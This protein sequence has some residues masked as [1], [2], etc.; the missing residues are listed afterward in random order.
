M[1]TLS[2]IKYEVARFRA[3]MET[4]DHSESD[5]HLEGFPLNTCKISSLFL[6]YHLFQCFPDIA[7]SLVY[8]ETLNS[9]RTDTIGH[10]WLENCEY[11]IDITADQFNSLEPNELNENITL[12]QP[13]EKV[14][15]GLINTQP[16]SAIFKRGTPEVL[17]PKF[18]S[19]APEFIESMELTYKSV[20]V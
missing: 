6:S 1:Y 20:C 16:H 2:E 10:Y 14:Y 5:I 15:C 9:T 12:F 11:L 7:L 3:E 4:I 13:L 19:L 18:N 8:G 17:T